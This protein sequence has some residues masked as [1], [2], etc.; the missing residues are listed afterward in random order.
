[1]LRYG[2]GRR[3]L[4]EFPLTCVRFEILLYLI[5]KLISFI[6]SRLNWILSLSGFGA[7]SHDFIG[8]VATALPEKIRCGVQCKTRWMEF[9]N[10]SWWRK[11]AGWRFVFTMCATAIVRKA[12]FL[13]TWV[14]LKIQIAL[15]R[16]GLQ[17]HLQRFMKARFYAR[18]GEVHREVS[19]HT[20]LFLVKIFTFGTKSRSYFVG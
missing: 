15:R 12:A 2:V 13:S 11:D 16:L 3:V 17:F 8:R 10:S 20:Y 19:R 9:I 4:P 1:M 7:S 18:R 5:N 14:A 6:Y